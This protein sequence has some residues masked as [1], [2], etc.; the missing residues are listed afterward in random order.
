MQLPLETLFTGYFQTCQDWT[1][2]CS[3][4]HP[5]SL[6]ALLDL[7]TTIVRA[8]RNFFPLEMDWTFF[9]GPV[10]DTAA[11]DIDQGSP[12]RTFPITLMVFLIRTCISISS[13]QSCDATVFGTGPGPW[14]QYFH[15]WSPVFVSFKCHEADFYHVKSLRDPAVGA[16]EADLCLSS[17]GLP[18][19]DWEQPEHP[20]L[21]GYLETACWKAARRPTSLCWPSPRWSAGPAGFIH[22]FRHGIKF[23]NRFTQTRVKMQHSDALLWNAAARLSERSGTGDLSWRV[24][25]S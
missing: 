9:E 10:L 14:K 19:A 6:L 23:H 7:S 25:P 17:P 8:K 15:C 22:L 2:S 11:A 13:R 24:W 5:H 4:I 12:E 20:R 16:S 21:S 1:P 3:R 18:L